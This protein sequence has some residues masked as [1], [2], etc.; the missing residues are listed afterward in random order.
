MGMLIFTLIGSGWLEVVLKTGVLRRIKRAALSI[1]PISLLFLFWDAYAIA[2]GHWFFDR[3]QI[4]GIFGPFQIPLEEYLFFIV[5]PLA[6]ILTIEG[7][8][9]VKPHWRKGEFGE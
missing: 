8:T 6:A 4:L 5:V 1:L 2:R 7:V 9:T 3:S